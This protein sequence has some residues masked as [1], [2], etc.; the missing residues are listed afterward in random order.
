MIEV[1]L[2][3]AYSG[4]AAG[5]PLF[6]T[7]RSAAEALSLAIGSGHPHATSARSN[8]ANRIRMATSVAVSQHLNPWS[9]TR[10]PQE[11]MIRT[12]VVGAFSIALLF[13]ACRDLPA[14]P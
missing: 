5:H 2:T 12:G 3:V 13:S 6:F 14:S 4:P 8:H 7:L 1:C 10:V 11:F 9:R